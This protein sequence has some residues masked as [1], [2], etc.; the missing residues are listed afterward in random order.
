MN[1]MNGCMY[2]AGLTS[3]RG[4]KLYEATIITN[5]FRFGNFSAPVIMNSRPRMMRSAG[6]KYSNA[7]FFL[8]HCLDI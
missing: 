2:A 1:S 6:M 5:P 7:M 4:N 3:W 8:I